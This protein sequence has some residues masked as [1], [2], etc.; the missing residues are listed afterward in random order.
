MY[1]PPKFGVFKSGFEERIR[2]SAFRD[3]LVEKK[4]SFAQAF[5]LRVAGASLKSR[6]LEREGVRRANQRSTTQQN[7]TNSS[8]G[9][10]GLPGL[11]FG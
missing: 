2:D 11:G 10:H 3:L 1:F 8:P 5:V 6:A 9:T 7:L 4:S